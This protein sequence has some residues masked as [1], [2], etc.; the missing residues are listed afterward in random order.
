MTTRRIVIELDPDS[1]ELIEAGIAHMIEAQRLFGQ[2]VKAGL[3]VIRMP[4]ST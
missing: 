2:A 1:R 4:S 3:G